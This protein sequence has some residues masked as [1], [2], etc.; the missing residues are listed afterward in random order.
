M[1]CHSI[2]VKSMS[3][4]VYNN[5][6]SGDGVFLWM[7]CASACKIYCDSCFFLFPFSSANCTSILQYWCLT[8]LVSLQCAWKNL[9]L[10]ILFRF[11]CRKKSVLI[12]CTNVVK[13]LVSRDTLINDYPLIVHSLII[14]HFL[15]TRQCEALCTNRTMNRT[16]MDFE[17]F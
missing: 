16:I 9:D 3:S 5:V 15:T 2:F 8:H 14:T 10:L 11:A 6:V 7:K 17:S 1:R 12:L 13:K 4:K